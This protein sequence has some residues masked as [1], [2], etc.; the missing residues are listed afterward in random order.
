MDYCAF[1]EVMKFDEVGTLTPFKNHEVLC[2]ESSQSEYFSEEEIKRIMR[3]CL[4]GLDYLHTE[5]KIVHRD[6]KPANILI[7]NCGQAKIA[8]FGSAESFLIEDTMTDTQGTYNF[9][10]PETLDGSSY[11]GCKADIWALGVT[12]YCLVFNVLPFES[13]DNDEL[14]EKIRSQ[15]IDLTKRKIS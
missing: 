13:S 1:G 12:L 14:F 3:D 15:P 10:A 2:L 6:L 11:S 4:V 8:D 7:D 9:L 5:K